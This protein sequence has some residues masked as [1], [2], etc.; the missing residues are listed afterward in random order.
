MPVWKVQL[1]KQKVLVNSF[2]QSQKVLSCRDVVE[3]AQD[4]NWGLHIQKRDDS[5]QSG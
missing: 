3:R 5:N 4:G 2:Q 1:K